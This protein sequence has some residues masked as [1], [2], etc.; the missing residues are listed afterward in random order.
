MLSLKQE[1][2]PMKSVK[3]GRV[4][5]LASGIIGILFAVFGCF[6]TFITFKI[7]ITTGSFGW[8]IFL[9]AVI[10]TLAA[11]SM[12]IYNIY[13]ALAKKRPSVID[14]VDHKEEPDP[15]NEIISSDVKY[16]PECGTKVESDD[17]FCANCGTKLK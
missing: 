7:A 10:W 11:L 14:I 15:L 4:P 2:S 9:F 3:Q 6:F 13:N 16:C 1:E 8:M 17:K 12:S 5:S